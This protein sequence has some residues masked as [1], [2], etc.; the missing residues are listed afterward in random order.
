MRASIIIV[1]TCSSNELQLRC[2]ER[3]TRRTGS[4]RL[5]LQEKD[6]KANTGALDP[7]EPSFATVT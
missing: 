3:D 4:A 5:P 6:W 7:H 1:E 2:A